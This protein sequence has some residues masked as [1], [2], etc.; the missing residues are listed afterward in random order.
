MTRKQRILRIALTLTAVLAAAALSGYLAR[1]LLQ[2][3]SEPER[4]RAWIGERGVW[5]VA[6]FM[7]LN[8]LQVFVAVIPGGPFS[9]AAGYAFGPL[10]GTLICLAATTAAST[11]VLLIVRRW[12]GAAVRF[13]SG[14]DPEELAL[15]QKMERAEWVFLL[16]FLIPGSP[17]DVLSYAAGL[18]KLPLPSWIVINL[19][20]RIPG[21]L[22]SVLGGD[23]V[24]RGDYLLAAGLTL[25]CGALY[26]VGMIIYKNYMEKKKK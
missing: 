21:I 8:M 14:K 13:L 26:I 18:M 3:L 1:P 6:A 17:K 23:R 2:F 22:L 15:F 11:L 7:L 19:I 5:G 12:G 4:F 20:G 10:W 9:M 16:V 25:L 24:M